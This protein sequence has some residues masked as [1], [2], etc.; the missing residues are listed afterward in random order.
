M[1]WRAVKL[2][3][4]DYYGQIADP[5]DPTVIKQSTKLLEDIKQI[6]VDNNLTLYHPH[7]VILINDDSHCLFRILPNGTI[8][9]STVNSQAVYRQHQSLPQASGDLHKARG[10]HVTLQIR[11]Q[12]ARHPET[13]AVQGPIG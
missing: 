9:A 10:V 4:S 7:H 8:I 12:E 1:G 11:R 2:V 3:Q 6:G 5:T 13:A